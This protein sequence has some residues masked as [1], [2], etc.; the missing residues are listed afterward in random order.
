MNKKFH[1]KKGDT[2]VI[3]T[4]DSKGQKGRVLNVDTKKDKAIVEG[5]NMVAKHTRPDNKNPKGGIIHK[6]APIH[7]SNLK[8]VDGSGK[9]TRVGRRLDEKTG[10]LVRYSKKSGEVIK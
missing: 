5:V 1:L 8:L 10:K 9:P 2:V 7:T 4:G 6:E 3:T